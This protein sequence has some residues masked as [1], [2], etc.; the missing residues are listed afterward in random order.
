MGR[1]MRR[2]YHEMCGFVEMQGEFGFSIKMLNL[3]DRRVTVLLLEIVL[4]FN[5]GFFQSRD[6]RL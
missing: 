6:L 2:K 4:S 5:Q 1:I 3:L